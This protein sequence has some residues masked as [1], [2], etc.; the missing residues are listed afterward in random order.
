MIDV[1][2][3]TFYILFSTYFMSFCF[4]IP[5]LIFFIILKN[6]AVV[7]GLAIYSWRLN[8]V[9]GWGMDLPSSWKFTYKH[10]Q[11]SAYVDFHPWSWP[12]SNVGLNCTGQ[13]DYQLKKIHMKVDLC[14][15]NPCCWRVNCIFNL[16]SGIHVCG[17]P[18]EVIFGFLMVKGVGSP[19]PHIVQGSIV[20]FN[21]RV[22]F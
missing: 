3:L 6:L 17:W 2:T 22:F 18:T 12:L 5:S 10:S 21:S 15:S 4:C 7:L 8:K 14:I 20:I 19:K 1:V 13:L 16:W 11:L 9:G